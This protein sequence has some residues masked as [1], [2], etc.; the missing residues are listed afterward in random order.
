MPRRQTRARRGCQR[1]P[2]LPP[3]AV[4]LVKDDGWHKMAAVDVNEL[5]Y[6]YAE[7]AAKEAGASTA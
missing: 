4:Y 2:P 6:K 3:F 1:S 7:E 5:H